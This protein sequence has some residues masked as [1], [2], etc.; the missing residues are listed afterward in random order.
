MLCCCQELGAS[1]SSV[2]HLLIPRG[3]AADILRSLQQLW[4]PGHD[5]PP[6][7]PLHPEGALPELRAIWGGERDVLWW[8]QAVPAEHS[9]CHPGD[10]HITSDQADHKVGPSCV[11]CVNFWISSNWNHSLAYTYHIESWNT[12][13]V[14]KFISLILYPTPIT[15]KIFVCWRQTPNSA[16][17]KCRL[18]CQVKSLLVD[19]VGN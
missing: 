17:D 19:S 2:Q 13:C 10:H 9:Q 11:C 5:Q 3:C 18:S 4:P 6:D 7:Q 14:Y 12:S 15:A 16:I 8:V 1:G